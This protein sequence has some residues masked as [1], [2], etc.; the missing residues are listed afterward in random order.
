MALLL[1][2]CG[3]L[4]APPPAA[5]ML[6]TWRYDSRLV[7]DRPSLNAGLHVT[8]AVDSVD[9]MHFAG[10]VTQWLAGDVGIS[11]DAFAPLTGAVD[12][13]GMVTLVIAWTT[14][15]VSPLRI[16]GTLAGDAL[17]IRECW[18]GT[19]PGPFPPGDA[20]RRTR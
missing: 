3:S 20:F 19:E 5:V 10:R 18:A 2:A 9:G 17:T 13:A 11:P 7:V 6:G 8:L 12:G 15:D 16:S 4:S 1:G 14:P